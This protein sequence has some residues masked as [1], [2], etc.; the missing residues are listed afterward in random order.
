MKKKK[1][2][3]SI[4]KKLLLPTAMCLS[5]GTGVGL[6][7]VGGLVK[8]Q[9]LIS[10]EEMLEQINNISKSSDVYF[11]SGE[12]LGTINSELIRK[13]VSYDEIGENV[14]NAIIASEDAN[15]YYNSGIEPL[16]IIRASFSELTKSSTTGGS[17]I[18]QQLVKNQ[19]LDNSRSYER[20][21]KEILLALRVD[22]NFSKQE[23]LK[24]YLNVAPFGKNSL[25]QNI[26]GIETAAQGIFGVS[27][28]DLNIAQ[29]AYLAGFVQS[30]YKYTPFDSAGNIRSDDELKIGLERQKYVLERMRSNSF[31]AKN[32]RIY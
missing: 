31:K 24:T 15:F 23:I 11:G 6:G 29:A 5:L 10:Q 20:K 27:S 13:V 18:T 16:A 3:T 25:G 2:S 21:A 26:S 1:I 22:N 8:D 12:K 4:L 7:F 28:K 17:T 30:P 14:K 9:P 32:I 19:L